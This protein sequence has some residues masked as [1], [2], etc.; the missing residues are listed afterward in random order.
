MQTRSKIKAIELKIKLEKWWFL[1]L[2]KKNTEI[3]NLKAKLENRDLNIAHLNN[4]L[5]VESQL[6]NCESCHEWT[7]FDN[8][9][10]DDYPDFCDSC[11]SIADRQKTLNLRGA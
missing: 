2:E 6:F 10:A 5:D 11:W 7:H 8:G 4:L 9:G 3:E 1:Q